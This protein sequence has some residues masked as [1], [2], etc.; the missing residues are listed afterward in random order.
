M[1]STS[2]PKIYI[3]KATAAIAKGKCVKPGADDQHV[4][5]A[6]AATDKIIGI[7]QNDCTAA[8][9]RLE[10]ALNGSGAKALIGSGGCAFGDMLVADSNGALIVKDSTD[11]NRVVAIAMGAGSENDLVSVEV[12]ISNL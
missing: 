12:A 1:A 4:Q 6:S 3:W 8:E 11:D 5:V 2:E 7:V 10:V 9:D